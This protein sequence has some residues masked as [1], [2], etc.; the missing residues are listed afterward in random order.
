MQTVKHHASKSWLSMWLLVG[1]MSMFC[2]FSASSWPV[3]SEQSELYAQ[4]YDDTPALFHDTSI[5]AL[6]AF[7]AYFD[8]A[9]PTAGEFQH[10]RC[11]PAPRGPP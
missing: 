2:S 7:T 9:L 5:P 3:F 8:T 10:Y 11:S 1:C 4:P 6:P